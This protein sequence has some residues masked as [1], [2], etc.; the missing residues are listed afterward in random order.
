MNMPEHEADEVSALFRSVLSA[1]P[2]YNSTAKRGELAKY[3]PDSLRRMII[4][5][6]EAVLLAKSAGQ[7]AGFCFSNADDQIVWLSWFGVHPECRRAGIGTALLERLEV[8]ARNL[9]THKIWCDSRT[10][11]A[12]SARLLRHSGY[13]QA[14][15]LERHWYGQDF[16]IW[17]KFVD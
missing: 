16:F 4:T 6:P 17:E 8:R 9:P 13:S 15:T 11:N 3:T 2:Y 12:P 1:L 5:D 10:D 14:C 7:L